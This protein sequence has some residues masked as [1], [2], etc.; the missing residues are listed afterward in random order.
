MS[1]NLKLPLFTLF[2]T[3]ENTSLCPFVMKYHTLIIMQFLNVPMT[4][5]RTLDV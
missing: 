2:K 1:V 5:E 4:A 3:A